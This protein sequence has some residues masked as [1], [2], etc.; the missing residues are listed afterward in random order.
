MA[1]CSFAEIISIS[2]LNLVYAPHQA[3][4]ILPTQHLDLVNFTSP[5]NYTRYLKKLCTHGTTIPIAQW[6]SRFSQEGRD[7]D[8]C[9]QWRLRSDRG[10]RCGDLGPRLRWRGQQRGGKS[11][12][13]GG[14]GWRKAEG[15]P[16]GRV[17]PPKKKNTY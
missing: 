1:C 16:N 12:D 13:D 10:G 7:S 6:S 9:L 4:N 8:R 5:Q 11:A 15:S 14:E 3:Q 17:L 2:M